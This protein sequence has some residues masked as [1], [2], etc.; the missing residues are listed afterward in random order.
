MLISL[1]N[2]SKSIEQQL[3]G[4]WEI[5]YVKWDHK[6]SMEVPHSDKYQLSLEKLKVVSFFMTTCKMETGHF[7]ILLYFLLAPLF[8]PLLLIRYSL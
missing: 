5:K 8:A 1:F 3:I 2:C 7:M 4:I 6:D